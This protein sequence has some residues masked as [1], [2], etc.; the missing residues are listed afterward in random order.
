MK[1]LNALFQSTPL[2]EGRRRHGERR[3]QT[4]AGFNPR[5]SVR[6]DVAFF[7]GRITRISFQSTPLREG[8]HGSDGDV[9]GRFWFQST[10]LREGRQDGFTNDIIE[11]W[12]QSTPLR[13]GRRSSAA[14]RRYSA[15]FNPRPSVRGDTSRKR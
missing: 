3:P 12:F 1:T 13:E 10:P 6:G 2:R 15:S 4:S 8:R 7:R 5:P 11:Q 9:S 14:R